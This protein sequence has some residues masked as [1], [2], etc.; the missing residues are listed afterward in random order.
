MLSLLNIYIS[1]IHFFCQTIAKDD[2]LV[3]TSNKKL[4]INISTFHR[5]SHAP[6]KTQISAINFP[7]W[8]AIDNFRPVCYQISSRKSPGKLVLSLDLQI[9]PC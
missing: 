2:K 6:L 7:L 3:R 4:I 5:H 1:P 8:I 9:K